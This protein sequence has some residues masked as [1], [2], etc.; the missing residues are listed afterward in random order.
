MRGVALHL[1]SVGSGHFGFTLLSACETS[2]AP[3]EMNEAHILKTAG[4]LKVQPRQVAATARLFAE[5][6][7]VPFIARYRKEATGSLDEVA[8]T[9]IR[10]RL[11][12]LAELDQRREAIL[13]SLTERN[14]LTDELNSAIARAETVTALED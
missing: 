6:A 13:K 2:L 12:S 4:E 10:E 9:S 14:L 11:L 1:I 5:G 7:T 3:V 8:I